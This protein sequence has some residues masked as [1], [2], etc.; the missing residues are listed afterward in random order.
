MRCEAW[1]AEMHR[2]I[3]THS[4]GVVQNSGSIR[5]AVILSAILF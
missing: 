2:A 3:E 1:P 5:D 4:N